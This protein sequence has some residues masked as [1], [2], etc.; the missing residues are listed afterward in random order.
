MENHDSRIA[1]SLEASAD[2]RAF[3]LNP[4]PEAEAAPCPAARSRRGR[5]AAA[6]GEAPPR[7]HV[8]LAQVVNF[9][10]S[11]APKRP[12]L[13][14]QRQRRRDQHHQPGDHLDEVPRHPPHLVE[15]PALRPA[16]LAPRCEGGDAKRRAGEGPEGGLR[17]HFRSV[18]RLKT[19][20]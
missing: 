2:E 19:A 14:L 17:C 13:P 11:R 9:G 18:M 5:L 4:Q 12:P 1:H 6:W 20:I 3:P 16:M 10:A 7:I 15:V 8:K